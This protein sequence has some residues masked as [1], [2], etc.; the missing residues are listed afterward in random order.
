MQTEIRAAP[1]FSRPLAS[2]VGHLMALGTCLCRPQCWESEKLVSIS[3]SEHDTRVTLTQISLDNGA[4]RYD[5]LKKPATEKM[6]DCILG[7]D[8]IPSD[9]SSSNEGKERRKA[10][11]SKKTKP[12]KKGKKKVRTVDR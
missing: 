3:V 2:M 5:I 4:S 8:K 9:T 7:I 1:N 10:K 12:K 6:L 11:A